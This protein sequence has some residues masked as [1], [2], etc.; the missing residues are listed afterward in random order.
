[1]ARAAWRRGSYIYIYIH[2]LLLRYHPSSLMSTGRGVLF[3]KKRAASEVSLSTS[4]H[5]WVKEERTHEHH[6][7]YPQVL[8]QSCRR[9]PGSPCQ[10]ASTHLL[11]HFAYCSRKEETSPAKD[12]SWQLLPEGSTRTFA[13]LQCPGLHRSRAHPEGRHEPFGP[14]RSRDAAPQEVDTTMPDGEGTKLMQPRALRGVG[15]DALKTR[16]RIDSDPSPGAPETN[17]RQGGTAAVG[18]RCISETAAQVATSAS[19]SPA[20]GATGGRQTIKQQE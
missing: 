3:P 15:Y 13:L 9:Q 1:M 4:L 6:G 16:E 8:T 2:I 10:E 18:E 20:S 12:K 11:V 7:S 17:P 19:R 5:G 14:A